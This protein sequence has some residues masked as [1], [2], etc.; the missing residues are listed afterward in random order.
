MQLLIISTM[1]LYLSGCLSGKFVYYE[2]KNTTPKK[3]SITVNKSK[4][5]VWGTIIPKLG[6]EFFV[7]NNLDKDSGLI[8]ISYNG[9]PEKYIDCGSLW[10]QVSNAKGTRTYNFL[11]ASSHE[12]FEQ[13]DRGVL[14]FIDRKMYLDGRMNIIVQEIDSEKTL[15]TANARYVLKRDSTFSDIQG[16]SG[17]S[18]DTITFNSSQS[19]TFPQNE[20][21]YA[22]GQFEGD[23]LA[24]IT[25][26]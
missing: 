18:S 17:S 23:V 6:S 19:G 4:E 1:C 5:D 24:L 13:A 7:I 25:E 22:T 8:N 11:A 20:T 9:S 2:P 16:R 10:S 21:C 14:Y 26:K 15:V 3:N 12:R